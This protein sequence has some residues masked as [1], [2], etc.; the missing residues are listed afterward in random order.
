[1]FGGLARDILRSDRKETPFAGY[2]LQL[3]GAAV[4]ELTVEVEIAQT[5]HA[6]PHDCRTRRRK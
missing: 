5:G 2:A 4:A 6:A 3:G 1:M